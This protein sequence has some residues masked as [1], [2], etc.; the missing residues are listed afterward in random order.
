MLFLFS[1]ERHR[2]CMHT[3]PKI[4]LSK[5]WPNPRNFHMDIYAANESLWIRICSWLLSN[6]L[7]HTM[8]IHAMHIKEWIPT[9]YKISP[10]RSL[11]LL[12]SPSLFLVSRSLVHFFS[13]FRQ[14]FVLCVLCWRFRLW[15][16]ADEHT[17][18]T[19]HWTYGAKLG[20]LLSEFLELCSNGKRNNNNE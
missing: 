2:W 6:H 1:M 19:Q 9:K 14:I 7:L 11:V 5:Q 17:V 10:S 15:L 8:C 20:S 3:F 18:C 16:T 12:L 13:R 4:K